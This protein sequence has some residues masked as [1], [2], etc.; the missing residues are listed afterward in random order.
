MTPKE[1]LKKFFGYEGFRSGQLDIIES[2]LA[3]KDTLAIM[4]TGGGKSICYQIPALILDGLT[5]VV[6]PLIALMKD[7]VDYLQSKNIPAAFINS[8]LS[9][10]EINSVYY[11]MQRNDLKL[12]YVAPERIS[13]KS[14]IIAAKNSNINFFAIDEAHCISEWGHDFRPSY[15]EI[16]ML[17]DILPNAVSG[18]F[19]ATA[20]PEVRD[21]IIDSLKMNSPKIVQKSFDRQNLSYQVEFSKDKIA[22]IKKHLNSLNGSAMIYC[23]SRKRVEKYYNE[24]K[25]SFTNIAYYHAGLNER[26]RKQQQEDFLSNK[27]NVIVAT[28]AF[29]MGIDKSD[30]RFVIHTDLTPTIESYYQEAGRAGRDGKNSN[31]FI[32]Y[33]EGDRNLQEFFI[34][35]T[36]P[37][38]EKI[39]K[40]YEY[41]YDLA[42]VE[43]GQF[44]RKI[45]GEDHNKIAV[46]LGM[47][48]GDLIAVLRFLERNR[49]IKWG[50]GISKLRIRAI[51]NSERIIEFFE[52]CD[53]L[54]KEVLEAI[55]RSIP[56]SELS[57]FN[58]IDT[59]EIFYKFNIKKDQFDN[60]IK[61]LEY[62]DIFETNSKFAN[63]IHLLL[64]RTG[65]NEYP[66][67]TKKY[68]SKKENLIKKLDEVEEY[69]HTH[70]CK[71]NYIL[72][73]FGELS[74]E[75]CGKCS[76]CLGKT[77]PKF[78][79]KEK[80][81]EM[82]LKDAVRSFG[83]KK[84]K[85]FFRE[86]LFG[87]N[88]KKIREES[89]SENH[90]FGELKG[91]TKDEFDRSWNKIKYGAVQS[92]E[93]SQLI[94]GYS[95]REICEKN[96]IKPSVL[97]KELLNGNISKEEL[98][99]LFDSS[100][101][102]AIKEKF[103]Q[104]P[105]LNARKLQQESEF[106]LSFLEIKLILDVLKRSD[107]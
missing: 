44:P 25:S 11:K 65:K 20:T 45:I 36:Y 46:A 102:F 91:I 4:P 32:L 6:S 57:R 51:A 15:R 92:E 78:E 107:K 8:S 22:S 101:I 75:N 90:F 35:K 82:T 39:Q 28:S 96:K 38:L 7:Q 60:A 56:L 71:R 10:E 80:F 31:C 61:Q 67:N 72:K 63:G 50:K 103:S 87:S 12:L 84:G 49:I 69:I 97:A 105:K 70:S 29:G 73:Y 93:K 86:L 94:A 23:G 17:T 104:N 47:D 68:L 24:L 98:N 14:F 58:E 55:L 5:I 26:F 66:F 64:A 85:T 21:D 88:T 34:R 41:L 43:V 19:T 2:I 74:N 95:F 37:D 3:G 76:Y 53:D 42:E 77:Q 33:D 83:I 40:V 54:S 100:Y 62:G 1:C 59:N 16:V 99:T 106:D 30:V 48:P 81:I 9:N 89:A 52:N 13:S 18:A 79:E 27:K